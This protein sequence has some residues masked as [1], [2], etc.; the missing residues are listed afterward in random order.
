MT[1][2]KRVGRSRIAME[3]NDLDATRST[4]GVVDAEHYN[5]LQNKFCDWPIVRWS[6]HYEGQHRAPQNSELAIIRDALSNVRHL[7]NFGR[8][9]S[10]ND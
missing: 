10:A 9:V 6:S 3:L 5:E 7:P 2:E 4:G 1:D 8:A